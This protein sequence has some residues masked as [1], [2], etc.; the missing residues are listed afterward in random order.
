ME[1]SPKVVCVIHKDDP[2][3]KP[4]VIS[5][6]LFTE[7][8]GMIK[9]H[10]DVN[11]LLRSKTAVKTL[12]PDVLRSYVDGIMRNHDSGVPNDMTDEQLFESILPR[13]LTDMTDV[14]QFTRY[15]HDNVED[16]KD[17]ISKYNKERS[18]RVKQLE[19]LKSKSST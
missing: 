10:S 9:F 6:V 3:Y 13:R 12:S 2:V 19:S 7:V 14:Y 1:Q 11:V 8:D 18:N 5:P 15:M 17:K 16:I 4:S